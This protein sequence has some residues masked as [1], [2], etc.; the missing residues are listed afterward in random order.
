VRMGNIIWRLGLS[1]A[2]CTLT[3]LVLVTPARCP[4]DPS[5]STLTSLSNRSQYTITASD[6]AKFPFLGPPMYGWCPKVD[7]I[8]SAQGITCASTNQ[9]PVSRLLFPT[10]GATFQCKHENNPRQGY[11]WGR[12]VG[13]DGIYI[14]GIRITDSVGYDTTSAPYVLALQWQRNYAPW[15]ASYN[16]LFI[17]LEAGPFPFPKGGMNWNNPSFEAQLVENVKEAATMAKYAGFAGLALN[18]ERHD[19]WWD[20]DATVP[21]KGMLM[22]KF[23]TDLGA[24]IKAAFPTAAVL[25]FPGCGVGAYPVSV[26]PSL[27]KPSQRSR[28]G[29]YWMPEFCWG[30]IHSRFAQMAIG[31]EDTF[32]AFTYPSGTTNLLEDISNWWP[33]ALKSGTMQVGLKPGTFS[34]SEGLWPMGHPAKNVHGHDI[35]MSNGLYEYSRTSMPNWTPALLQRELTA[36]NQVGQ[37]GGVTWPTTWIFDLGW[38]WELTRH[39]PFKTG[40]LDPRF[41]QFVAAVKAVKSQFNASAR[42][43]ETSASKPIDESDEVARHSSVSTEAPLGDQRVSPSRNP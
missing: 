35:L 37:V 39:D 3:I 22:E 6:V 1:A 34:F 36:I 16:L 9:T 20:Q 31:D 14:G 28:N 7:P 21:N 13:A 27:T 23:G 2:I 29:Y 12:V 24:A 40:P 30:F 38:S 32:T 18:F 41:A 42:L 43:A 8:A 17:N 15:G 10:N 26:D 4:L 25:D 19:G 5:C 11:Y 33:R